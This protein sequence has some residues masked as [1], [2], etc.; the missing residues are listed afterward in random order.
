MRSFQYSKKNTLN[1]QKV[2]WKNFTRQNSIYRNYF[3]YVFS[4]IFKTIFFK[5]QNLNL[6]FDTVFFKLQSQWRSILE[7]K[8]SCQFFFFFSNSKMFVENFKFCKAIIKAIRKFFS[9]L[10]IYYLFRV[11]NLSIFCKIFSFFN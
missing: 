9:K 6:K 7:R 10:P 3:C 1:T 4:G 11:H 5:S 2:V 8:C